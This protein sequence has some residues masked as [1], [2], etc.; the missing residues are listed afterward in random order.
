MDIPDR[1]EHTRHPP[2]RPQVT[3]PTSPVNDPQRFPR[4]L[5]DQ[6][7]LLAGV[8]Q[9]YS[10]AHSV[11][12]SSTPLHRNAL[13]SRQAHVPLVP[14]TTDAR[15]SLARIERR[16]HS[17]PPA[18][19][20]VPRRKADTPLHDAPKAPRSLPQA[21]G[22]N[23]RLSRLLALCRVLSFDNQGPAQYARTGGPC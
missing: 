12:R 16:F 22:C 19:V 14:R 10:L 1:A 7:P 20:V 6:L 13:Q 2:S 18:E 23:N 8:E 17:V 9:G 3:Q 15:I 4:A 21:R 11:R 5:R